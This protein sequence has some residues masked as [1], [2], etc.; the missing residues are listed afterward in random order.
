MECKL[1]NKDQVYI[2]HI[3]WEFNTNEALE[4]LQDLHK[5]RVIVYAKVCGF[6]NN[7]GKIQLLAKKMDGGGGQVINGVFY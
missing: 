3:S 6:K 2:I 7:I 4:K 5:S 1:Q